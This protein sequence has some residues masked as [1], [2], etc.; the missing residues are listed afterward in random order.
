MLRFSHTAAA[1]AVALVARAAIAAVVQVP[2]PLNAD[3]VREVGGTVSGGGVDPSGRAFVTQ[4]EAAA[5]EGGTP[6]G[7]PDNGIVT[8][9]GGTIQLGPYNGN[10]A[11]RFA[12]FG[13]NSPNVFIPIQP[14]AYDSIQIYGAG[15]TANTL[16]APQLSVRF[17]TLPGFFTG[18]PLDWKRPKQPIFGTSSFVLSGLDTTGA[19]GAGF[20]NVDNAGIACWSYTIPRF[21]IDPISGIFLNGI[22]DQGPFNPTAVSVFAVTLTP[23]PEPATAGLAM[24]AGAALLLRRRR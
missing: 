20:D 17:Q 18:V 5:N 12:D 2:L 10:N 1:A 11:L 14:G 16:G 4:A 24:V 19:G 13:A 15:E 21:G 3:V 6:H 22:I 23:V 9:S 8:V 7:L